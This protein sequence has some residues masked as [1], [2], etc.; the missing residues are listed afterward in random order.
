MTQPSPQCNI[1]PSQLPYVHSKMTMHL[2][3]PSLTTLG[4]KRGRQKWASAQAKQQAQQLDQNWQAL[5]QSW[6][7]MSPATRTV[8]VKPAATV[9]PYRRGST[10]HIPSVES[11]HKGAVSTPAPQ[12]YT[13]DKMIGIGVLHKSNAVPVFSSEEATDMAKMRR[14]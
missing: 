1:H 10:A 7:K 2:A 4:K 8:G 11:G 13:G 5:Q 9:Q 3:H 12:Y 14:G 6:Q